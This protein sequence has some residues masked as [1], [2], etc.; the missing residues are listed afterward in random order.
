MKKT[1]K[2]LSLLLALGMLVG[3]GANKPSDATKSEDQSV[4]PSQKS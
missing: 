3:C 1:V 4:A 2:L